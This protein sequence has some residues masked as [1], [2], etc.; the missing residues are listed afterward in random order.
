MYLTAELLG[1]KKYKIFWIPEIR[2]IKF[3]MKCVYF[4]LKPVL[5]LNWN[6]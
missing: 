2:I 5:N 6:P 1:F 4:Q 3:L